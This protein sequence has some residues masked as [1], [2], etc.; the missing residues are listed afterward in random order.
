[1]VLESQEVLVP[2]AGSGVPLSAKL[3]PVCEQ[4]AAQQSDPL[5]MTL[6]HSDVSG[7]K[8]FLRALP[9][10]AWED[11]TAQEEN[12]KLVRPAHDA[13]GI[14]KIVFTFC[15]DFLQKVFDLPYSRHDTWR[16]F[17]APIY[18]AAG[19]GDGSKIVRSLL[20]SMPPGAVI[21]V[22]HDT[23]YWVKHT[24]RVHVAIDSSSDHV[25]FL[26]GPTVDRMRKV[27][28]DEGR[29]VELNN[30]AK[31]AVSNS[32]DRHRVHLIFDYVDDHP[33]TRRYALSPGDEVR[34]TRRS[35]DLA[36]EEGQGQPAPSFIVIG[37]Q[38]SG[39]TSM[40]EY[41]CVHP[42]ILR[43]K[44]RETHYFDWRWNKALPEEDAAAHR[45]FFLNFFDAPALQKHPSLITGESTPSYLLHSD[46]VIPRM[47]R[48]CPWARLVV[49]LRNP[50]DRAYS[51]YQMSLDPTGTP[52]QMRLR[53]LSQYSGRR[54]AEVVESEIAALEAM[55]VT[56]DCSADVFRDKVLAPI[57]DTAHG[58]HSVVAR[59]LYALQL[60][61]WLASS[62]GQDQLR[63]LSIGAI[64]GSRSKV[65]ATMDKVYAFIGVPPHELEEAQLEPKNARLAAEPMPAE[66]RARLE[67][68][69]APFNARLFALLGRDLSLEDW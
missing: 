36:C 43:G 45:D 31:H 42:L 57:R 54:F 35:I 41:L 17:L 40:Y 60:Q 18:A 19:L 6:G 55:G 10:E 8:A 15:D 7:F 2:V 67:G 9:P 46:V 24:H 32:W 14:K 20:A 28:F 51:Q 66:V 11:E 56:P 22:H 23:G 29:I 62:F 58:G 16:A 61:P 38:K 27:S 65:Q 26:V 1:M 50:V 63:V 25:D 44:R 53:G 64:K 13:W 4:G 33:I 48:V 49:M 37:A 47:Q 52:E 5:V 21:P 59:G 30:Q 34:Q 69:Y 3:L 68:F 39:T 12:V